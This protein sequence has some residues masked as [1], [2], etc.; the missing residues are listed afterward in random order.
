M[1]PLTQSEIEKKLG[2]A[3]LD[4]LLRLWQLEQGFEKRRDLELV[5][6]AL[7]FSQ[8]APL[9]VLDLCCGPGD[10]GRAIHARFPAAHVDCVDR[11][12]FLISM[13]VL[14]NRRAGVPGGAFVRDLWEPEWS[15][16]LGADYDVVAVAN[17][18]HWLDERRVRAVCKDVYALLR[19][20]AVF[21]LVEPTRAEPAFE[22]AFATWK[23]RQ[24]SRYH[25]E[26]WERF[27]NRANAILG[28]DHTKLLGPRTTEAVGDRLP[29]SGWIAAMR[30]AGF[31]S[32][33]VLLRDA[34][35]VM[36]A[37]V[38]PK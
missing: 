22:D 26:D 25:R 33:D 8:T 15:A 27:W 30:G 31:T 13:C 3:E 35:E 1:V 12:V 11:D 7:P 38:R 32:V 20:G 17:A 19:G 28:Y 29:V 36:L 16:G 6:A 21:V 14:E 10:V 18:L 5:A 2:H 23:S 37:A 24:P 34:D 9:R 4:E